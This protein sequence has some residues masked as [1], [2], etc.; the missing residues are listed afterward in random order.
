MAWLKPCP[1]G[2]QQAKAGSRLELM[3]WLNYHHLFYFWTVARAGSIT[4]ACEELRLAQP[5]V[6]GQL[7][8]DR[9]STRLNSSH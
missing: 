3:D 9:K 2:L 8:V 5:T 1:Y 4:K 6:S 7:R